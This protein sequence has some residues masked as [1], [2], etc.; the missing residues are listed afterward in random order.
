[1][2]E[3]GCR[4]WKVKFEEFLPQIIDIISKPIQL[5]FKGLIYFLN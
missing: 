2:D 4:P 5:S 3:M 1:M